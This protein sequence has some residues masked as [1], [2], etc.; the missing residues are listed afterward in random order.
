M[1]INI[2]KP[3]QILKYNGKPPASFFRLLARMDVYSPHTSFAVH[4]TTPVELAMT[5]LLDG[6]LLC[7]IASATTHETASVHAVRRPVTHSTLRTCGGKCNKL[8]VEQE[9]GI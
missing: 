9:N 1:P 8:I 4:K 2:F 5:S 7:V 3:F 6:N